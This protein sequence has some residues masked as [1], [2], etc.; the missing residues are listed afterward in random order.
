[1]T[2]YKSLV[3]FL[4]EEYDAAIT[5]RNKEAIKNVAKEGETAPMIDLT[6]HIGALADFRK[7]CEDYL[8][9]NRPSQ[10]QHADANY[11]VQLA[12]QKQFL[13][14]PELKVPGGAMQP[15]N[16]VPVTG[17]ETSRDVESP[18]QSSSQDLTLPQPTQSHDR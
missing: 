6:K 11:L 16:A 1:M 5:Q 9:A 17:T 8:N 4:I 3:E 13:I 7:F 10:L 12:N 18:V 15:A 14:S 2:M